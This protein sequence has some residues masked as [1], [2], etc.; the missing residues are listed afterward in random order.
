M[1]T[2]SSDEL[3]GVESF[4]LALQDQLKASLDVARVVDHPGA[5]G[6]EAELNWWEMLEEHLPQCYQVVSKAFVVD[7]LG[8]QSRE[9]DLL[10]CDRQYSPLILQ[11]RARKYVPAEAVYAAFEVKP[12]I[13]RDYVFD[14]ARK[15]ASVRSLSRTS[16]PIVHAGG[17]I[18]DPKAPAHIIG[19]LLT[20]G[21]D[22]ADGLGAS[23]SKALAEQDTGGQLDLG[24][25]IEVSGWRASYAP[26][27]SVDRSVPEQALVYFFVELLRMLQ[28]VGTVTA[29]EF[30]VWGE[31][32]RLES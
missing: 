8:A 32:L 27:P 14:A 4:F 1:V 31:F 18:E 2:T 23:F 22:W 30:D 20:T 17:K 13:S 19:G 7:H 29:M 26:A 11:T 25:A 12:R 15:T 6:D 24:C 9:I 5:K 21:S 10:L 3:I 16:A 28:A